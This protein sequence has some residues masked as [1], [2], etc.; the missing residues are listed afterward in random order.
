MIIQKIWHVVKSFGDYVHIC[1]LNLYPFMFCLFQLCFCLFVYLFFEF[2]N[3]RSIYFWEYPLYL[4]MISFHFTNLSFSSFLLLQI[5]LFLSL[6]KKKISLIWFRENWSNGLW[7]WTWILFISFIL[8]IW[9]GKNNFFKERKSFYNNK[10]EKI[11]LKNKLTKK[12]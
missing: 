3:S 2:W 8:G 9:K 12:L 10:Q 7:T 11:F 1:A 5:K 4:K 6:L